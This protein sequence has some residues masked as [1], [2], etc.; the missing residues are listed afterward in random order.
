[1]VLKREVEELMKKLKHPYSMSK[2]DVQKLISELNVR[3][4]TLHY[5]ATHDEKTGLHNINFFKEIFAI[6]SG[7]ALSGKAMSYHSVDI[8]FLKRLNDYHGH[9]TVDNLLKRVG[10]A[11]AKELRSYDVLARF[12]G[13][14]FVIMTPGTSLESACMIADKL[15]MSVVKDEV[16]SPYGVTLS[17]GVASFQTKD[18]FSTIVERADKALYRAKKEGRNKVCF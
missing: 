12:G 17:L 4:S 14:E 13:D 18:N 11:L 10:M 9:V 2:K 1:M 3:I 7:Q 15:R 16:L 8:D 5:V 6:E